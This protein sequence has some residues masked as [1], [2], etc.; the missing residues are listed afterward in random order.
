MHHATEFITR[1]LDFQF[2]LQLF[3]ATRMGNFRWLFHGISLFIFLCAIIT[4]G[5]VRGVFRMQ[6]EGD[7]DLLE[8]IQS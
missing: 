7:E 2:K 3:S 1:T 6:L 5:G 8:V 4:V